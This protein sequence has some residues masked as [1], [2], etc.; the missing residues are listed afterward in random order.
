MEARTTKI[1]FRDPQ[2]KPAWAALSRLGGDQVSLLFEELRCCLGKIEGVIE[3]QEFDPVEGWLAS[4][5]LGPAQLC[6]LQILPGRLSGLLDL[7]DSQL[8]FVKQWSRC[9]SFVKETLKQ[10]P[11]ASSMSQVTF[12]LSNKSQVRSFAALVVWLSRAGRAA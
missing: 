2:L 10:A 7:A 1:P 8:E 9:S 4:Y 3:N 5:R 11:S 6:L 12:L